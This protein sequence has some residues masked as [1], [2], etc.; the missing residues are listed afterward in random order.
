V[1]HFSP[2]SRN[3]ITYDSKAIMFLG[4][5]TRNYRCLQ[6]LSV[7]RIQTP[8]THTFCS[9]RCPERRTFVCR[10]NGQT[11]K[12]ISSSLHILVFS[13]AL[14]EDHQNSHAAYY[15]LQPFPGLSCLSILSSHYSTRHGHIAFLLAASMHN[16]LHDR[17]MKFASLFRC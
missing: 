12:F 10:N 4:Q 3:Q 7:L 14:H 16:V 9:S 11:L 6:H 17:V 8:S 5:S 1:S 15:L 2:F 13:F